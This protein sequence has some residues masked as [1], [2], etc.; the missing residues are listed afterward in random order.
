M[1][2][3]QRLVETARDQIVAHVPKKETCQRMLLVT[4]VG[5][6]ILAMIPP[7]RIGAAIA[8]RSLV[9]ISS[10]ASFTSIDKKN[11]ISAI[12]QN[13]ARITI[14]VLGIA[15]LATASP[16][17][18]TASLVMDLA[19]QAFLCIKALYNREYTTAALHF[20]MVVI[21]TLAVAALVTGSWQLMVAAG[22][23][24]IVA[25]ASITLAIG[26]YTKGKD[27]G[28]KI[29]IACYLALTVTGYVGISQMFPK[30]ETREAI[31]FKLDGDVHGDTNIHHKYFDTNGNEIA[32]LEAGQT[33]QID[34]PTGDTV[35][36][37]YLINYYTR[38]DN[39]GNSQLYCRL[40]DS[41][42]LPF[43]KQVIVVPT[44]ISTAPL[45]PISNVAES[46]L[47]RSETPDNNSFVLID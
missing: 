27:L 45:L 41:F 32:S 39:E 22:A 37:R 20:G 46:A 14:I 38:L 23:T 25:M 1:N 28:S 15:A 43:L 30:I 16:A 13:V 26:F 34:V 5:C 12:A 33:L 24:S 3:V 47:N 17:L 18:L 6:S 9:L 36:G 40:F 4:L 11:P 42:G 21:D 2:N 8:M 7:I 29:D 35:G 10:L 19:M 44:V 31:R